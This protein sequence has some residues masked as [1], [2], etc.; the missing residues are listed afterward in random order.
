MSVTG[1]MAKQ[2]LNS[3]LDQ[4]ESDTP[5]TRALGPRAAQELPGR[6]AQLW[7]PF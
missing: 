3:A 5:K 4:V 2:E 1:Q 6:E 7:V